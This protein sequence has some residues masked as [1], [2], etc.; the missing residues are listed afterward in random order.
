LVFF[1]DAPLPSFVPGIVDQSTA[2]WEFA[3]LAQPKVAAPFFTPSGTIDFAI[4]GIELVDAKSRITAI[5]ALAPT[6]S[7]SDWGTS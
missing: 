1:A 5:A 4:P 6:Q 3:E 7:N 2:L